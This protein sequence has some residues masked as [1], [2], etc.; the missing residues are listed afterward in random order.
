[1]R[2][3]EQRRDKRERGEEREERERG[4][5]ERVRSQKNQVSQNIHTFST[6]FVRSYVGRLVTMVFIYKST[7]I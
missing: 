5:C 6:V 4:V 1:M 3:R 7:Y 2:K